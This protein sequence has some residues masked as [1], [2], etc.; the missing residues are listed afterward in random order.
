QALRPVV[1]GET[2]YALAVVLQAE[3]RRRPP[4]RVAVD[5]L[6]VEQRPQVGD[7]PALDGLR[8][9]VGVQERH[10]PSAVAEPSCI[11][12]RLAQRVE[13]E[14]DRLEL[15]RRA[16]RL[17]EGRELPRDRALE[18]V[19]LS[20]RYSQSIRHLELLSSSVDGTTES[21]Y[22]RRSNVCLISGHP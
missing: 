13:L 3:E 14:R 19:E 9:P 4:T 6:L 8:D 16:G 5:G 10:V 18:R 20:K 22:D 7:A 21:L 15:E 11:E 17:R 1:V 2:P 12:Q